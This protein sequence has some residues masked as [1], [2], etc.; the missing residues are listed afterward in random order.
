MLKDV[1][2]VVAP[3]IRAHGYKGSGQNY[4]L[5]NEN[6]V[7]VVKFQKSAGGERFYVNVGIQPLFVPTE[8]ES[9][10]NAKKIKVPECIFRT[11]L[12]PPDNDMFGW[13]YSV[14][15]AVQLA[16]KF[17]E[18]Y[19]TFVEP[20]MTIPGPIT[21]ASVSDFDEEVVHPLL[22]ARHARNFLHFARISFARGNNLKA[23]EFALAAIEICPQRASSLLHHLKETLNSASA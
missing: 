3:R 12:D 8:S 13:P 7:S 22:G 4:R 19:A 9:T 11:R 14:D 10:A 18:L 15:L 5:A 16:A 21:E 2:A 23:S 1:L 17:D 20:L 6:A